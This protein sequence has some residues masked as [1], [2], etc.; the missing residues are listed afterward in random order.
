MLFICFK[1]VLLMKDTQP[2]SA[3]NSTLV[4]AQMATSIDSPSTYVSVWATNSFTN[5]Q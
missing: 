5:S 2:K 4:S 3:K 1:S